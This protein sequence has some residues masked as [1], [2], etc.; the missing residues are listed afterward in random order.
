MTSPI[1]GSQNSKTQEKQAGLFEFE[2]RPRW[3]RYSF[4]LAIVGILGGIS[5]ARFQSRASIEEL[6]SPRMASHCGGPVRTWGTVT[7]AY[8]ESPGFEEIG[9]D[10]RGYWLKDM[11]DFGVESR[12]AVFYD[13]AKKPAPSLG[14]SL[15]IA[16]ILEC[17]VPRLPEGR[18]I[19]ERDRSVQ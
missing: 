10:Q 11:D 2:L 13:P 4:L 19:R 6:G 3:P 17:D 9:G 5:Y 14:Q 15:K 7:V 1:F 8:D 16:G 12:I 18:S